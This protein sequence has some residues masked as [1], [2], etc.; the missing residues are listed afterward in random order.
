MYKISEGEKNN[1]KNNIFT[2][3]KNQGK[4][5]KQIPSKLWF[6]HFLRDLA[7]VPPQCSFIVYFKREM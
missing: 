5:S 4:K 3:L 6:I 1:P 7:E 2:P